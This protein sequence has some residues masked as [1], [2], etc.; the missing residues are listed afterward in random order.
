M[1][2]NGRSRPNGT[3][4]DEFTEATV[5]ALSLLGPRGDVPPR[6]GELALDPQDRE[7]VQVL[8]EQ[9]AP[10]LAGSRL[11]QDLQSSR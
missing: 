3:G 4:A 1:A 10:A 11:H 5:D 2:G 7:A 9:A 6:A 8:A